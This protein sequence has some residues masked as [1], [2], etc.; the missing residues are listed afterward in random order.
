MILLFRIAINRIIQAASTR[1]SIRLLLVPALCALSSCTGEGLSSD[2]NKYAGS[3]D[4]KENAAAAR[5]A[6]VERLPIGSDIDSYV[7]LFKKSGGN[8]T[9]SK[10]NPSKS[11]GCRYSR[12]IGLLTKAEWIFEIIYDPETRKSENI[13]AEYFVTS[14]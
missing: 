1:A 12:T 7:Q 11:Y 13:T 10:T 6:L 9:K 8:C 14:L 5:G 2:L 4:A 3:P